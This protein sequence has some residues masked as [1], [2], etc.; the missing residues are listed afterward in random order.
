MRIL[1][2][3]VEKVAPPGGAP[4]HTH[5]TSVCSPGRNQ[6]S[7]FQVPSGEPGPTLV[8]AELD[9]GEQADLDDLPQQTQD[10]VLAALLQVLGPYVDHVAADGGGRVQGQVQVLLGARA[11]V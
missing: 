2:G 5:S 7:Q 8:L 10:Q 1:C 9:V 4:P 11:D 3:F 6:F